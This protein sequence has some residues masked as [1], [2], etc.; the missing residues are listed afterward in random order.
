MTILDV[1]AVPD[2]RT[3]EDFWS[4]QNYVDIPRVRRPKSFLDL[5]ADAKESL[6]SKRIAI[7]KMYIGGDDSKA[8]P[9][10]TSQDVID[11]ANQARKDLEAL[12]A[13]VVETDFPLVTN[14]EDESVIGQP[15][16][17][18]GF[19]P[20][21]NG[22]ERGELVAYLWDDF[23]KASNDSN[24]PD[25]LASADGS[26]MFPRPAGLIPDRY[27]EHR[28]FINYPSLVEIA[29]KRNGKSI[30]EID[31]IAEALPA[32]EAQ[33]K[34]DFE[35]WMDNQEIDVMAFPANGD[36]GRA[37]IDFNDESAKHALQNGIRYSNGNRAIRHMG[38]PT[39]SVTMGLM[40]NSNMPVNLTFAGKHGQDSDLLKYA[41]AFEQRSKRRV[42]PPVTPPLASDRFQMVE[43]SEQ[44]TKSDTSTL[45]ISDISARK[46]AADQIR[47]EGSFYG[48]SADLKIEVYVDG[49]Q[50]PESAVLL[51][52]GRFTIDSE[53]TA[54]TPPKPPYGGIGQVVGNFNTI[55]L[56]RLGDKVV[57]KHI[58][59]SQDAKF[60]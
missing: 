57:G 48:S 20:D 17:V 47:I 8:K 56:A 51:S 44:G 55:V 34:R 27:M 59:V 15:N 18:V 32:L 19:K 53:V 1:L 12:G 7:P 21:W 16:N 60:A 4:I 31:G 42:A 28:N 13:T 14:Y 38:I 5:I 35:D 45:S 36:I 3:D 26:Q 43:N 52:N 2:D 40:K 30:W 11:L 49:H 39:V 46:T 37:D 58:A 25:G 23:L 9:V 50:V 10:A 54:F 6:R 22:K 33:R 29:K 24:F 41:Y